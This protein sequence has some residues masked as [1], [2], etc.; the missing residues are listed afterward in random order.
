ML[1]AGRV[2][3]MAAPIPVAPTAPGVVVA[4]QA[5]RAMTAQQAAQAPAQ[6]SFRAPTQAP[7]ATAN[8]TIFECFPITYV[9]RNFVFFSTCVPFLI[10]LSICRH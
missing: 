8:G 1:A 10:V 2:S 9:I 5:Q 7:Y 4:P 3:A 6:M